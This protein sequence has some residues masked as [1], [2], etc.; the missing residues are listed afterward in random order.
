MPSVMCPPLGANAQTPGMGR[1]AQRHN[2][3]VKA[4][5]KAVPQRSTAS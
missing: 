4:P 1:M 3:T 2:T 5:A